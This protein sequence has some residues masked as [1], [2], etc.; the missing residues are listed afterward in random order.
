[1]FIKGDVLILLRELADVDLASCEGVVGWVKK[2][3]VE[4]DSVASSSSPR[5][6]VDVPSHDDL[7]RTVLIAPSPPV[8]AVSLPEPGS[9]LLDAPEQSKRASGPFEFES[10]AQSP[11]IDHTDTTFF[12]LQQHRPEDD[13]I[14]RDSITSIA[15]SEALGGIGGFMMGDGANVNDPDMTEELTGEYC[16]KPD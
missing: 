3:E 4:F 2:G 15:S 9:L 16:S 10:P 1:M 7:P 8:A 12:S 6:S 5:A 11:A 14:K 13:D